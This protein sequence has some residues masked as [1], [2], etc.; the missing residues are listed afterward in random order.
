[1]AAADESRRRIERNLHD[2]TQQR[3]VSLG[4]EMRLA[5][6][7]IPPEQAELRQQWDKTVQNLAAVT[8]DLRE[9]SRG[10]HPAILE[11]GGLGPALRALARRSAVPVDLNVSVRRRLPEQAEITA[12]YVAS[13]ALT[14]VAKHAHASQ[15]R[16]EAQLTGSSLRLLIR[17]DGRGG[18]D[19]ARG[20]G[21]LGIS[22]RV[23]AANGRI[24]IVSPRGGGT[25]LL[26]MI[27]V[28]RRHDDSGTD[29]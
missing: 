29:S 1:V 8:E 17:D 27:P 23:G 25:S 20:S 10:L 24:E 9:V 7:A 2:S 6:D 13:E 12:Y 22:D 3:L 28:P 11:D 19:P 26:A 5:V 14:N 16:V 18:A 21:L 15:V 4:L